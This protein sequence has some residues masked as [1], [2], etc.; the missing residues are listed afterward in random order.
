MFTEYTLI[1]VNWR[2]FKIEINYLDPYYL[3]D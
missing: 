2:L 3:F 1:I